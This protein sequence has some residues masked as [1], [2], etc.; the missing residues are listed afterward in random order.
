MPAQLP[1]FFLGRQTTS[2]T[3]S[4]LDVSSTGSLTLDGSFNG[5]AAYCMMGVF[6]SIEITSENETENVSATSQ[7]EK[8]MMIV[9]TATTVDCEF[10]ILANDGSGASNIAF[11]MM[12]AFDYVE[13]VLNRASRTFT[14]Y[15]IVKSI[16][17]AITGKGSVTGTI[18]LEMVG[19]G[20]SNPALS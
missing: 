17:Q 6:K 16:K 8:N 15:G 12:Y 11:E 13:V 4:A 19:I 3:L 9:E 20:S 14:F 10:L 2:F 1:N 18:Q 7:R 5:G